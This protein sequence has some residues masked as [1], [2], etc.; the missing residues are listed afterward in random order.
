MNRDNDELTVYLTGRPFPPVSVTGPKCEQM[1][2]HCKGK[3]LKGMIDVR[4]SPD[5]FRVVNDLLAHGADGLLVSGGC[6]T[7]GSVPVIKE[8]AAI[9]Y[10][11][12]SGLRVNVHTGFI[13]KEDAE[14]LV[15]AGVGAFSVDVHQDP[16][17]IRNILHLEIEED[18]YS[19]TL[20]N[21]ISAGGRPVA[22]LTVGFGREDLMRSAELIR[23]KGFDETVLIAL[24]PTKGT[25]TENTLVAEEEILEAVR[26]LIGMGLKVTL[27]CMRPRVHR[28]LERKCIEIGVR[29]IA[30]PTRETIRWAREN[31]MRVVEMFTCCCFTR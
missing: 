28:D 12:D 7:F 2:E 26:E 31:G 23:M 18:A 1:C 19:E 17:I 4:G 11:A 8:A 21:I 3:H 29:R 24:V 6:D 27:G 22:H 5:L 16:D 15:R 25:I 13:G 14:R 20:D 30:N 9:R 10:A